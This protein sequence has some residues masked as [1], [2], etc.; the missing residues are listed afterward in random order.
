MLRVA[1]GGGAIAVETWAVPVEGLSTILLQEPAGLCIGKVCL[2]D[3]EVV[4]GVLAEPFLC[5]DRHEI[6]QWGGWRAY[7]E[8]LSTQRPASTLIQT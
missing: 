8:S 5:E 6:T 1:S 2:S 7:I 3:G 4:L